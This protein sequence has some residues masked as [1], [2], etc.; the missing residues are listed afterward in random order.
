LKNRSNTD[1][2]FL[3]VYGGDK[4]G[5]VVRGMGEGD[6][7][8][9]LREGAEKKGCKREERRKERGIF[10]T[11]ACLDKIGHQGIKEGKGQ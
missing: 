6:E 11:S 9:G 1:T 8:Q 10:S 7:G 4:K 3:S 2:L 5:I